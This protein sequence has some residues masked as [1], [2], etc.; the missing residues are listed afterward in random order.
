LAVERM[1]GRRHTVVRR[2][3]GEPALRT[4][5]LPVCL[6]KHP[7]LPQRMLRNKDRTFP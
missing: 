4:Y 2:K 5:R 3:I 1:R 7:D 6:I